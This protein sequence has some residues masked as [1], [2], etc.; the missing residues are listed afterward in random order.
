M[1]HMEVPMR[2]M[3][4]PILAPA[5]ALFS[6]K[7]RSMNAKSFALKSLRTLRNEFLTVTEISC[8][9]IL[10]TA[11]AHAASYTVKAGGGGNYTTIQAC[12]NAMSPGDTCTVYAG[13]YNE[14][15]N[16]S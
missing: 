7:G 12:A 6:C 2:L 9:F 10:A 14:N 16:V 8:L 11:F 5:S 15:V 13:T 1:N 3:T 4:L